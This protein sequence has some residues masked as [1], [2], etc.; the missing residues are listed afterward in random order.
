MMILLG[1][2]SLVF[3]GGMVLVLVMTARRWWKI[4]SAVD[5]WADK[6]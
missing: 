4:G 6:R 2:L 5:R 3:F 1:F